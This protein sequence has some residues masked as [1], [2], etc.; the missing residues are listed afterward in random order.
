M[1][2]EG[3]L[4]D[5]FFAGPADPFG[6]QSEGTSGI[7]VICADE[8]GRVR[9]RAPTPQTLSDLCGSLDHHDAEA[10]LVTSMPG[11]IPN[12]V[13]TELTSVPQ[14]GLET[15]MDHTC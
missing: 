15:E 14:L 9:G 4:P 13:V 10:V 8:G 6:H 7:R 3:R 1:Q 5:A 12:T 11:G 2:L